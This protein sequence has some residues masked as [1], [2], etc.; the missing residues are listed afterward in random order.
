MVHVLG[1][2]LF[3]RGLQQAIEE[4]AQVAIRA[5]RRGFCVSA[6]GAHG[7]VTC[8]QQPEFRRILSRFEINLP[9]G[10]PSVWI[11]KLKGARQMQRCYGPDF[12]K[13]LI[14]YTRDMPVKHFFCGGK[15]A[16][17]EELREAVGHKYG[18]FS[19][20]GTYCP[21]FRELTDHEWVSLGR[22]IQNSNV[23]IVWIGLSTP[24]QEIFAQ[25]LVKFCAV[26]FIITVGAAFDFHTGRVVQAPR[27]M[28]RLG[29][30]WFFRLLV[31]PK[32]L[33][34]RYFQIVPLFVYYNAR[35]FFSFVLQKKLPYQH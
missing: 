3:D 26:K 21:P 17:A 13:G 33:W 30:E 9:D 35:E 5:E 23:D 31:E 14:Q 16:V 18:N 28:Q 20:V 4:I 7:L 2:H 6:T 22:Q 11:G 10:M 19:I 29:L 25:K 34:R 27:L 32:R 15:P 24:K 1:I 8:C 12:F